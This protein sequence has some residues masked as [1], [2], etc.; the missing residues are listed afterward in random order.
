MSAL[1]F[2]SLPG[3]HI[4]PVRGLKYPVSIKEAVSGREDRTV[5]ASTPR[6]RWRLRLNF[7]RESVAAPAPFGAYTEVSVVDYFVETHFGTGDSFHIIDPKDRVTDRVVRFV[8]EPELKQI[9][10]GI[11]TADFELISVI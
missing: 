3:L 1:V 10:Q 7:L 6:R 8:V 2:P 4:E 9:V 11:W 5:W